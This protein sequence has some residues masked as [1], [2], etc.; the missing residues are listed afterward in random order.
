LV[1]I[2]EQDSIISIRIVP[3][4]HERDQHDADGKGNNQ[5]QNNFETALNIFRTGQGNLP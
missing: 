4:A 5:C 3:T 2:V 1:L